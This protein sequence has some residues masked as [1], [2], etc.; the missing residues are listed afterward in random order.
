MDS[1]IWIWGHFVLVIS[2][3][4]VLCT[5]CIN[6]SNDTLIRTHPGTLNFRLILV[7]MHAMT[8]CLGCVQG[9][10]ALKTLCLWCVLLG[11]IQ[12]HFVWD[13][14][15]LGHHSLAPL[16]SCAVSPSCSLSLSCSFTLFHSFAVSLL[17]SHLTQVLVQKIKTG[18][19]T[20]CRVKASS[21]HLNGEYERVWGVKAW[22]G[23]RGCKNNVF[24]SITSECKKL[25]QLELLHEGLRC[26]LHISMISRAW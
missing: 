22:E 26:T 1:F 16:H 10:W 7:W 13:T 2:K 8:P 11:Y 5:L 25:K 20:V 23:I 24:M 18:S 15:C 9:H 6:V 14:F 4:T 21:P 12:G 19:V 17:H 3:D